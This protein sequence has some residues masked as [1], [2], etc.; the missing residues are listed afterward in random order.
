MVR[1]TASGSNMTITV[2]R[3]PS[4][5][6]LRI[7]AKAFQ[8]P[9]VANHPNRVPFSGV[10]VYVDRPSERPPSGTNGRPLLLTKTAALA[11]LPSLI[12]M[13]VNIAASRADHALQ[14]KIGV[15]SGAELIGDAIHIDGYLYGADCPVDVAYIKANSA[16]LG[17]S[18]EAVNVI[19]R[20]RGSPVMTVESLIF[21]G[22]AILGAQAGAYLGTRIAA[23]ADLSSADQ[24]SRRPNMFDLPVSRRW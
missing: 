19:E 23:R 11:A 9:D 13:A 8:I 22:A 18:F 14:H 16:A 4:T 7:E 12:G 17:F 2:F 15:I 6:P 20:D 10:L 21:S 5:Q 24:G 1:H 3:Q